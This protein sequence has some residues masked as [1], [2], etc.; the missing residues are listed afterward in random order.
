MKI[1][2]VLEW[3]DYITDSLS[4]AFLFPFCRFTS[5]HFISNVSISIST[6]ADKYVTERH[7]CTNE[8]LHINI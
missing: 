4:E 2:M 5:F 8:V 3:C 6:T 1:K 7:I